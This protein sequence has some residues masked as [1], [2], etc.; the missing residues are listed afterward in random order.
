MG[1]NDCEKA[2]SLAHKQCIDT[3]PMVL[4]SIVCLPLKLD[5]ICGFQN[6]DSNDSQQKVCDPS[7]VIDSKFGLKYLEMKEIGK[8]FTGNVSVNYA[9]PKPQHDFTSFITSLSINEKVD[10]KMAYI[11]TF[12]NFTCGILV[13][14]Y[15][16][17]V[18]GR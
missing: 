17:I 6:F 14:I 11:K 18:Y 15:L 16:K 8:K 1:L 5:F 3:V 12:I 7:A 9:A 2:F 4:D 10:K 13:F